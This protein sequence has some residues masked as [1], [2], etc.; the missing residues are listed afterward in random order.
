VSEKKI[1][2]VAKLDI[3]SAKA[4]V[5]DPSIGYS[6]NFAED[7]FL[8][9]LNE[10]R[11]GKDHNSR[12]R[13]IIFIAC[14]LESYL[15]EWARRHM[16]N[17]N[18]DE[19]FPLKSSQHIEPKGKW[20]RII[21]FCKI[22]DKIPIDFYGEFGKIFKYRNDLVHANS[23]RMITNKLSQAEKAFINKRSLGKIPP[24]WAVRSAVDFIRKFHEL[25]GKPLPDYIKYP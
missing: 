11:N 6:D 1:N 20:N 8:D 17:R 24:G 16:P 18:F 12:R 23:S 13:E 21:E 7:W 3:A 9:A 15:L 2:I 4:S 22:K 19:L 25:L 14:F 10:A 5:I